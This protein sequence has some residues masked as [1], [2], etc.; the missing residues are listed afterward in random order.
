MP[1]FIRRKRVIIILLLLPLIWLAC[2]EPIPPTGCTDLTAS[3]YDASA[4]VDDSSCVYDQMGDL[5]WQDEFD[6]ATLNGSKWVHDIGNGDWGWGNG[7]LQY[8]TPEN[9]IVSNGTVK[10]IARAEEINGFNYSSSKI[11]TDG[12][13]AFRYG[14]VQ[15]RIKTLNGEGFWPAFWML[16]SGGSWPCDGEIDIMEQWGNNGSTYATTGAAH[17]GLCPYSPSTHFYNSFHQNIPMGS[18]A[19]DFH[20]YEIRWAPNYIVWYLDGEI[21]YELTPEMYPS[22][23]EWPFNSNQWYLILNL[24]ITNSGPNAN[25]PFPSQIEIDWVRVYNN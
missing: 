13:F 15:A 10:I 18:Y 2:E 11:K 19:D 22:N 25:T 21:I 5:I 12:K 24:A 20:I 9:T 4:L 6:G 14:K 17:L 16:P 8:Y 23:F 7:E 3:N 1:Q